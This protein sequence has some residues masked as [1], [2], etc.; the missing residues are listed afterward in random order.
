MGTNLHRPLFLV[1][2]SSSDA[3]G[4]ATESSEV[5][6]NVASIAAVLFFFGEADAVRAFC[7]NLARVERDI[8]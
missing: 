6:S 8:L 2:S 7:T 1:R 5:A 3:E 4:S